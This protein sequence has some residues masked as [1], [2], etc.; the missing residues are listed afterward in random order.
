MISQILVNKLNFLF[1]QTDDF[2]DYEKLV[3]LFHRNPGAT[4]EEIAL[5]T[6]DKKQKFPKDYINFLRKFNGCTLFTYQGLGGFELLGTA[7]ILKENN[8][9]RLTYEDDWDNNLTVFCNVIGDGD[10]ISFKN[11]EDD[12]YSIIDCYHDDNPKNWKVISDSLD[13]FLNKLIAEKGKRFW[14]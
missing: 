1:D 5:M 10:F 11:N 14:L 7:S 9:Q 12:S 3:V 6:S 8:L 2:I 13:D 4:N